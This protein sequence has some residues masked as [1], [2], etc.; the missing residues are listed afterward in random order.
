[1]QKLL[2]HFF[3]KISLDDPQQRWLKDLVSK[4]TT[5]EGLIK[6]ILT[7]MIVSKE[8]IKEIEDFKIA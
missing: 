2:E 3:N 4:Q 8:F 1:M 5:K 6:I 7:H